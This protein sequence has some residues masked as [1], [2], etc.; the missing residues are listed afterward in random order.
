MIVAVSDFTTSGQ[1]VRTGGNDREGI[2]LVLTLGDEASALA[3]L[4]SLVH[5]E[6]SRIKTYRE[7]GYREDAD[8]YLWLPPNHH[9]DLLALRKVAFGQT[10]G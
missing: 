6:S 2:S 8:G 1:T 9:K 3:T 10:D 4:V 7:Y 5:H